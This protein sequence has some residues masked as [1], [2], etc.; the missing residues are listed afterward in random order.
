M[1]KL[2]TINDFPKFDGTIIFNDNIN[3]DIY[4]YQY[5]STSQPNNIV[6]PLAIIYIASI[7][8]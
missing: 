6:N 5:A 1:N 8:I 4:S 2:N 7:M 3:Y